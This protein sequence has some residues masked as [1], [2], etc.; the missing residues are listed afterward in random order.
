MGVIKT[1]DY[2]NLWCSKVRLIN[3]IKVKF[4]RW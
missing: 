1:R 4:N 2:Y 3:Q